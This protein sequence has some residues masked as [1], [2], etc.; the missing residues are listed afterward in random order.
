MQKKLNCISYDLDALD[1]LLSNMYF[2][3]AGLKVLFQIASARPSIISEANIYSF[4]NS[5]IFYFLF[6]VY[7][8]QFKS[9]LNSYY[10]KDTETL[11][12]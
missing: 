5:R 6:S 10:I 7:I 11:I 3:K 12:I 9:A 4:N 1:E 2:A 8:I